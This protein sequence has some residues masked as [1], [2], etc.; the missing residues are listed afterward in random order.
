MSKGWGGR[1]R[2][3]FIDAEREHKGR[4]MVRFSPVGKGDESCVLL[5]RRAF[6]F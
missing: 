1:G 6:S 5:E 2:G 4:K 3:A